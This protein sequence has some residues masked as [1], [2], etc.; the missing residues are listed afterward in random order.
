[1]DDD[2]IIIFVCEHGAAKSVVAAAYFN[3]LANQ[4]GVKLTALARGTNPDQEISQA[5]IRGLAKDGLKP[6][7]SIPR[8][9]SFDEAIS[10]QRI[11][12]FCELPGEITQK[13]ITEH[14]DGIPAVSENYDQARD[15]IVE[16]IQ[17]LLD[18]IA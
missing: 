11:I 12:R 10:A 15:A 14:W 3:Q 1:M 6:T 7:E 8:N 9:L 16:R 5:A 4:R 2:N 17:N 18:H 13:T